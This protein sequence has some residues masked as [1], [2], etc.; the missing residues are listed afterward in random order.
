MDSKGVKPNQWESQQKNISLVW[1]LCF[2]RN[3]AQLYTVL[4]TT[5]SPEFIVGCAAGSLLI[6]ANQ[7]LYLLLACVSMYILQT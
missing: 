4:V 6:V 1:Y 3:K 7:S 5:F 2:W